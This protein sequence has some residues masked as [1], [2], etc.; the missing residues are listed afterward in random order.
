MV[1]GV[2]LE[3]AHHARGVLGRGVVAGRRVGG[4]EGLVIQRMAPG[5]EVAVVVMHHVGAVEAAICHDLGRAH[6]VPLARVVGAVACRPEMVGQEARPCGQPPAGR[7]HP[8]LLRVMAGHQR[9]ARRPAAA[10]VVELREPDP[11]RR[12]AVE[13]RGGN[14]AAVAPDVREAEVV[15]QDHEE[16]GA[17]RGGVDL[18]RPPRRDR[19]HEARDERGAPPARDHERATQRLRKKIQ[20]A[21]P[22]RPDRPGHAGTIW[23]GGRGW[24]S[25]FFRGTRSKRGAGLCEARNERATKLPR[26]KIQ[27]ARPI[28][29]DRPGFIH[30][31]RQGIPA[32]RHDVGIGPIA[33]GGGGR[34]RFGGRGRPRSLR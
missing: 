4:R 28:R 16:V 10:R 17:M 13:V 23:S 25:R 1:A 27:P 9:R 5:A 32:R 29:P 12:Q 26:K 33:P 8:H 15:G 30:P 21:R 6:D 24:R 14:L 22:I 34:D 11:A 3:E 2:V 19:E 7:V 20:P 31:A 18:A